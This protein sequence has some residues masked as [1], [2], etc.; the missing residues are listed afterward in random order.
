[1]R[2]YGKYERIDIN[3]NGVIEKELQRVRRPKMKRN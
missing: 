2:K 1:M 3:W